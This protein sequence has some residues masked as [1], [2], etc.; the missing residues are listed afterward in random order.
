MVCLV[1]RCELTGVSVA[2]FW[3]WSGWPSSCWRAT[4]F[5]GSWNIDGDENTGDSL[6]EGQLLVLRFLEAVLDSKLRAQVTF[7][8]VFVGGGWSQG[9]FLLRDGSCACS[10]LIVWLVG[11][12]QS[13]VH[14]ILISTLRE[15]FFLVLLLFG[16]SGARGRTSGTM[17]RNLLDIHLG[18]IHLQTVCSGDS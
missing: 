13:L 12:H 2:G 8:A 6:H 16:P 10:Y 14:V 5:L 4:L 1:C 17:H 15:V 11:I 18:E 7:F 3:R 9:L